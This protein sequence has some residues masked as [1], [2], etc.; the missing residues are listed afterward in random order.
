ATAKEPARIA[1]VR[2][3][4]GG[5][6]EVIPVVPPWLWTSNEM[7]LRR[8]SS[9]VEAS[10]A[11]R[12]AAVEPRG[13]TPPDSIAPTETSGALRTQG[14]GATTWPKPQQSMASSQYYR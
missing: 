4:L 2:S 13:P 12:A 6:F 3:R 5:A 7:D 14:W 9:A 10:S 11:V 8:T 1:F